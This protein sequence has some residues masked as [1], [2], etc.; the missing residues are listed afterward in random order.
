M[1]VQKKLNLYVIVLIGMTGS[2]LRNFRLPHTKFYWQGIGIVLTGYWN[3]FN[4]HKDAM[5][6]KRVELRDTTC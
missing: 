3:S 2:P 5:T 4:K 6:N 1:S